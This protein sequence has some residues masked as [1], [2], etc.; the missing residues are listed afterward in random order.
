MK[1]NLLLPAAVFVLCFTTFTVAQTSPPNLGEL[2]LVAQLPPEL[3]QRISGLAYDGEQLWAAIYLGRGSYAKLDPASL[4]WTI[5]KDAEH[6]RAIAEVAGAFASPGGVCFAN[7]RLWVAGAYGQSFGYIDRNSWKVDRV[8]KRMQR[9]DSKSQSYASLACDGN[10]L[11]IAWHWFKYDEPVSRTQLLLQVDPA[12]GNVLAEY[13]LPSGTRSD[14]THALTWDGE[15]LWHMKDQR[16]SAI[17]PS[18]GRVTAQY[19]IQGVERPSGLAWVKGSMWI[20]E[21][22]GRIWHLPFTR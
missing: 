21:F 18:S 16:L 22:N 2:K 20:S 5:D 17:D 6:H 13:P 12:T 9:P 10:N 15:K 8:F 3:P 14:M 7:E 1:K 19:T 11:W 4:T